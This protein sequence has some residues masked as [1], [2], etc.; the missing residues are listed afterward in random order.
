MAQIAQR[1]MDD[2]ID[3]ELECIDRIIDKINSDPEPQEYKERELN[4][5]ERVKQ[6]CANGRRTGTG[7]TALADTLAALNIKYG[8]KK[9][10]E[11][12][13][14][15]FKTLKFGCY[16]SSVDMAQELWCFPIW[17]QELEKDNPFLNRIKDETIEIGNYVI[18][19][20]AL[21]NDMS[22]YGRRNI[23][24][25]TLSPAGTISVETQTTSGGEP[26]LYFSMKRRKKGNM[27]DENFRCDFT[28]QNG[29]KW[30]EFEFEHP[31]LTQWR[32]VTG[33]KNIE[34]SP[35]YGCCAEDLNY[36]S[37]IKM[38]ATIQ[39][40]VDHSISSTINLPENTTVETVA[41]IYEEAWKHGCKGIT[42]YRKGCRTGVI[43]DNTKKEE[44]KRPKEL[45]CDVHHISVHGQ[46]YF[47][48]VGLEDGKPIEC[49]AGRNGILDKDIK[50][51]KIVKRKKNFY[52]FTADSSD[53]PDLS[54]I[55]ASMNEMERAISRLLSGLLRSGASI[56]FIVK[57]L[58][59]TGETEELT[60][61]TKCLARVLRHYSNVIEHGEKCP[62][63]Q[64]TLIRKEGCWTCSN[65]CGFT[66]CG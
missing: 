35:W 25:L 65:N 52:S 11:V 13:D 2:I 50:H 60:S 37:R 48:L 64:N 3:L 39:K 62:E 21:Y 26:L 18:S 34:D 55:T 44:Q 57:Q 56:D 10:L 38:Q 54:P 29:D 5:W 1:L 30:M 15:I 53:E 32:E 49:F 61:F 7:T 8:S 17:T 36:L 63:C 28:D 24:C 40:H 51:G 45:L 6:M 47:V 43:L 22:I 19:G 16:R 46:K 23:A 66:K 12:T 9:S 59:K 31:K 58:E 14:K 42:I 4:M 27:T 33:K 41:K 20:A